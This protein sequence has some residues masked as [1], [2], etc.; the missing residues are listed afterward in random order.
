MGV[1]WE[2]GI[3]SSYIA[4]GMM[5]EIFYQKKTSVL[6]LLLFSICILTTN[7]TAGYGLF[8]IA[9]LMLVA[10]KS[11]KCVTMLLSLL[12]LI[13]AVIF[14]NNRVAL[15]N[16]LIERNPLVFSKLLLMNDNVSF[17]D[18][19][20]SPLF[21]IRIFLKSP[22]FGMGLGKVD[23]YYSAFTRS[24]QTSTSTFYLAAFGIL[25]IV[26]TVMMICGLLRNKKIGL[27]MRVLQV[28]MF[29]I[30]L[31]KEPHIFFTA[32][33]IILFYMISINTNLSRYKEDR[34]ILVYDNSNHGLLSST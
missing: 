14:L 10:K 27:T 1:F 28:I 33:Y 32:T 34:C 24:S 16:L 9:V 2:P 7:S 17:L 15:L 4:I 12:L 23:S 26:P 21:N 25:G 20:Q 13:I 3:Y 18:R 22:I 5:F 6:S 8:I 11:S 29:T 19:M 31:N 30:I